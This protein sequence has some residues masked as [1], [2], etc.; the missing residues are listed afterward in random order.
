MEQLKNDPPA[1]PLCEYCDGSG[2]VHRADGEW[3][4]EC[5]CMKEHRERVQA[6]DLLA[7]AEEVGGQRVASNV[8]QVTREDLARLIQFV[9]MQETEQQPAAAHALG[10]SAE[11]SQFLSAVMDAAGLVRHGKRSKE[12]SEYLGAQC[13]KYRLVARPAEPALPQGEREARDWEMKAQGIES[14]IHY[15]VSKRDQDLL[16]QHA[17][18]KRAEGKRISGPGGDA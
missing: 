18:D 8:A 13:L 11:F 4:G 9:R 10:S 6:G 17:A 2:D 7:I 12:L 14:V 5:M 3:L 15:V 1:L 16:R